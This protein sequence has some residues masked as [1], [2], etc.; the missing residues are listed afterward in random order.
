MALK[1]VWTKLRDTLRFK[2]A[3]SKFD[4]VPSGVLDKFSFESCHHI[5]VLKLDGKLGDTQ[6][7]THFYAALRAHVPHITLSVVCSPNLAPI[8]QDIL[9][10]DQVLAASRKPKAKE[11][12]ELCAKIKAITPVSAVGSIAG[13]ID[14]VVTTEPNFRPRDF[15]FNYELAPRYVAGCETKVDSVNLLIYDPSKRTKAVAECFVDLMDLGHLAHDK[16]EYTR[17]V[18]PESLAKMR[19]WLHLSESA[20]N[21]ASLSSRAANESCDTHLTPRQQRFLLA[22][23]P[24]ASSK[25]RSFTDEFTVT[26][27]Q[28]LQAKFGAAH[29]YLDNS[30]S[31]PQADAAHPQALPQGQ[32]QPQGQTQN[33]TQNLA[34]GL[35]Q[36]QGQGPGQVRARTDSGVVAGGKVQLAANELPLDEVDATNDAEI[37]AEINAETNADAKAEADVVVN[38]LIAIE[39]VHAVKAANEPDNVELGVLSGGSRAAVSKRGENSFGNKADA[40]ANANDRSRAKSETQST[41]QAGQG[42]VMQ[43][44]LEFVVLTPPHADELK[45]KVKAAAVSCGASVFFLPDDSTVLDLSSTIDLCDALISVDTA[46]V[47]MAC[48]SHRPQLC[49]YTGTNLN[50]SIRWAPLEKQAEVLRCEGKTVPEIPESMLLE[51]ASAFV[52]RYFAR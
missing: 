5:V 38:E 11:I 21:D 33:I 2:W 32:G 42:T 8:Y 18:T 22:I 10:F 31:A 7:M 20:G 28:E 35:A 3:K 23:N 47:H 41:V 16:I 26:L 27:I 51:R 34:Q 12:K 44:D 52:Q 50:E 25:S 4:F 29:G 6:V 24:R 46:A 19:K 1:H 39:A 40:E 48:A 36:V 43:R 37:N 13:K 15:I 14:L 17:L 9:G 30:D 45:A 49:V